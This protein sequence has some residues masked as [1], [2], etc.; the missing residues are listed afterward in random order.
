MSEDDP[1]KNGLLKNILENSDSTIKL[2]TLALVIVS[3]GGNL[4]ATKS[5]TD[6]EKENVKRALTRIYDLHDQLDA[7]ER[8]QQGIENTVEEINRKLK[9]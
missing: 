7:M 5:L 2:V 9:P 4:L 1:K 3:G 8:R 6:R